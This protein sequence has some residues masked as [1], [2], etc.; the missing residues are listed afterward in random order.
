MDPILDELERAAQATPLR[1]PRI[2]LVSNLSGRPHASAPDAAYFRRH[3]REP[4]RFAAG[5]EALAAEGCDCFLEMGP[6][7]TLIDLGARCLPGADAAWLPSLERGEPDFQI[8]LGSVAALYARGATID[9]S[10]LDRGRDRRRVALPT[11]PSAARGTGSSC[12]WGRRRA[13]Q[14][15]PSPHE[16]R[17]RTELS[18]LFVDVVD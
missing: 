13:P 3:A 16:P 17:P 1:A 7:T 12:R 10:A 14:R 2:P 9:A 18:N 6:H 4:V 8:L 5:I 15:G 11:Y